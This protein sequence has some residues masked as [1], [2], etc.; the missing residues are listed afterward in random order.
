MNSEVEVIDA[1][2]PHAPQDINPMFFIIVDS[3][4]DIEINDTSF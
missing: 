2:P 3:K 4:S 1:P